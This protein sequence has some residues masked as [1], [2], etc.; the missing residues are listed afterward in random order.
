MTNFHISMSCFIKLVWDLASNEFSSGQAN[1]LLKQRN[2]YRS[3]NETLKK[4]STGFPWWLSGEEPTWQCW[5]H[6]F[7][8]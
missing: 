1:Q 2:I 5:R 6:G 8:P 4:L 7:D 3:E